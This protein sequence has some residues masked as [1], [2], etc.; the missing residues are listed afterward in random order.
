MT[1]IQTRFHNAFYQTKK[2]CVVYHISFEIQEIILLKI[3]EPTH[4]WECYDV[5]VQLLIHCGWYTQDA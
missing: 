1:L 4:C 5:C 2:L 3:S